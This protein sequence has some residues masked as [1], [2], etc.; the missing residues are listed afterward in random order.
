MSRSDFRLTF[1]LHRFELVAVLGG[2]LLLFAAALFV[3]GKLDGVGVPRECFAEGYNPYEEDP[4]V[5]TGTAPRPRSGCSQLAREFDEID[6]GMASPLFGLATL[7]PVLAGILVGGPAVARELERGTLPLAW[8]M[9]GSRRRWLA[10]RLGVLF[11]FLLLAF[12]P[13]ALA[14]DRLETARIPT[15][16][17]AQSFQH[18]G[19]RGW[20]LVGRGLAAFGVTAL[21][22]LLVGRQVPAIIVGI[23][24]SVAIALGGYLAVD[25]WARG[26]AEARSAESSGRADRYVDSLLRSRADGSYVSFDEAYSM[27][28]QHEQ[29]D[30]GSWFEQNFEQ[31][32]M[33][34]PGARYRESELIG[35][36][37]LVGATGLCVLVAVWLV[38]RRRAT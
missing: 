38:E 4:G 28:P 22:G 7:F 1:K 32:S 2:A 24:A 9:G 6:Y 14:M 20:V 3:V 5:S 12:V 29:F 34:V 8:T 10:I 15:L 18:E 27:Q 16:D 31:I 17:S 21:L 37:V 25:S 13:L 33:V 23:I 26:V 19:M 35:T 30:D 36:G 11:A